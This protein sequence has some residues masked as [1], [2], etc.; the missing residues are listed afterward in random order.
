M[1]PPSH[2]P[3]PGHQD[4]E[5]DKEAEPGTALPASS[6]VTLLLE[7]ALGAGQHREVIQESFHGGDVF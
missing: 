4:G 3:E 5:T 7:R 6:H 2:L 1:S